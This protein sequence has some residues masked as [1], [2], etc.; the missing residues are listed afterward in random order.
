M[1]EPIILVRFVGPQRTYLIRGLLDSGA[2][3]TLVPRSYLVKLGL[4]PRERISLRTAAGGLDVWLG[5]LDLELRSGRT[6]YRWSARVGFVP[7]T[8]I[9]AL[10]GHSGFLDHFSVTFDGLRKRHA[11]PQWDFPSARDRRTLAARST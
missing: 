3:M 11:S 9:L 7:R 5:P 2:A 8:D 10:L 6:I 1:H 4:V